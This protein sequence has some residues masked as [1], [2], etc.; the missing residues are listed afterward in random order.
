MLTSQIREMVK[1]VNENWRAV[2]DAYKELH[3]GLAERDFLGVSRHEIRPTSSDKAV[4]Q[5]ACRKLS[6]A[7]Q[8]GNLSRIHELCDDDWISTA[9]ILLSFFRRIEELADFY[10]SGKASLEAEAPDVQPT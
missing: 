5:R 2:K 4:A 3:D 10:D 6:S 9:K 8:F 1:R 7:M